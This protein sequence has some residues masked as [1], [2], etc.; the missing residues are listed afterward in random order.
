MYHCIIQKQYNNFDNLRII[1][2]FLKYL[3][4]P[5]FYHKKQYTHSFNISNSLISM[6]D[7]LGFLLRSIFFIARI[8]YV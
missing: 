8:F 7:I 2:T 5:M 1:D 4:D 6:E 3:D